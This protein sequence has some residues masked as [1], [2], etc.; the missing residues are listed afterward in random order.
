MNYA[1]AY[2]SIKLV[3]PTEFIAALVGMIVL[4]FHSVAG[5]IS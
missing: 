2:N 3:K 4:L 1:S 5:C